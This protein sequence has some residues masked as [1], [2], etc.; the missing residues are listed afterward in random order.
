VPEISRSKLD[1]AGRLLAADGELTEELIELEDAF[2]AYR[3]AHLDPLSRTTLELQA[4]LH[5]YGGKYYIAQRLK[6]KPQIL[7]KLRRLSVRLT[8]LQDIGGSRIIV[9]RNADVDRLIEFISI[10]IRKGSAFSLRRVSDYRER[11]RD[12]TGYR[13]THLILERD[14][15]TLELQ[16]RS[17][18]QHY[19]AESIERSSVIYG[20]HLKEQEGEPQVIEYFKSLSDVF[21]EIESGRDPGTR[22]KVE[23][24]RQREVAQRIIYASDRHRVF[25]SYVNEEVVRTLQA[26]QGGTEGLNNWII[27]FDWKTGAFVTWDAVGRDVDAAN[28]KY[29]SYERQFP[30]NESFEVVMIGSSDIATVRQT[31][32]HYFGIEKFDNILENLD[33]SIVGL[34]TRMDIDVGSRQ[35]LSLLKR[36]KY[37]GKKAASVDTLKNHFARG[38]V[39]FDASLQTLRELGLIN[40]EDAQAPVSLNLKR[41]SEI[42][43]YL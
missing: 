6:R 42:E 8:Q 22:E 29:V 16:V 9:D 26:V 28:Q 21:Y 43:A 23:L 30:A 15:C 19:W 12:Q 13:G 27:V 32:S 35:I 37:W 7:R 41:K 10:Q 39:T 1:R 38:V 11:G 33:Q 18:I 5:D 40:M 36:K 25:D 34:K 31:H 17:R 2:D 14:G 20:Y 3:A 24:D 4:W